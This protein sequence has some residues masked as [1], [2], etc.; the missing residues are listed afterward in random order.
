MGQHRSSALHS[1]DSLLQRCAERFYRESGKLSWFMDWALTISLS[2]SV[3]NVYI[4]SRTNDYDAKENGLK[5]VNSVVCFIAFYGL[6]S[7][8]PAEIYKSLRF[9]PDKPQKRKKKRIRVLNYE[10]F[11][12]YTESSGKSSAKS[13]GN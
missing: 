1:S 10:P 6:I 7:L 2:L 12:K 5:L 4:Q 9:K 11:P 13:E 8:N 3:V